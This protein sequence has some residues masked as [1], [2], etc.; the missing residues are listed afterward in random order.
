MADKKITEL[1]VL[2]DNPLVSDI[3]LAVRANVDYQFTGTQLIGFIAA[4]LSVGSVISFSNDTPA[5][6]DGKNGDVVIK[7]ISGQFWQKVVGVWALQY[8]TPAAGSGNT[9]LYGSG[10]PNN[11]TGANG[12]TYI[13]TDPG[14]GK[15]YKKTAGAWAQVFSMATGPAGAPGAPGTPGADGDNGNTILNGITPPSNDIGV[16]GDFYL[17]TNTYFIYGPK[18]AGVWGAGTPLTV[19]IAE[20]ITVLIAANDT[21][22]FTYAYDGSLGA[23]P[24]TILQIQI[25][26]GW[27]FAAWADIM[28]NLNVVARADFS[29]GT[30]DTYRLIIK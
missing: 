4:V 28:D 7:P 21:G 14:A 16:N 5:N 18:V 1:P 11:T 23:T 24:I 30:G 13:N 27:R 15:F 19:P 3:F 20:P 12:D 17:N 10:A 29:A 6:G 25:A 22:V 9:V 2:P 26:G 8:T